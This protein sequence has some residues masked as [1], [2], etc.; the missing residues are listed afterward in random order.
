MASSFSINV[1][2]SALMRTGSAFTKD[3][4]PHLALAVHAITDRV[5]A[6]WKAFAAGA[7]MPNGKT[8]G[9]R[10]G[11]YLR[12][13]MQRSTGDFSADVYSESPHAQAIESGSPRRDLKTMLNSSLKV[14]LSAAGKRFLVIPFRHSPNRN[15]VMR[16]NAMPASVVE[17]WKDKKPSHVLRRGH[18][19]DPVIA[20]MLEGT[21]ISPPA[22]A[23]FNM[24]R[25]SGT[26]AVD[27][28]TG[29]TISVPRHRYSWGDRLSKG[30]LSALGASDQETRRMQGMVNFRRPG[31]TGGSAH[32]TFLTFRTMVEGSRG[33]I[34]PAQ[35]GKWPARQ[36]AEIYQ[37]V[38]EELFSKA[39]EADIR[40]AMP[41][42]VS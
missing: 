14:R 11:R 25:L 16:D 9:N 29:M 41:G 23:R 33:W 38:A 26:R 5:E 13:I 18:L 20:E 19:I 40:A 31:K 1:D 30:A 3:A 36:V 7:P 37:P 32:S 4:F 35:E 6:R 34:A 8:I 21:G 12:S 17:W 22:N 27:I 28:K 39:V 24:T 15:N 42:A 10:S 2:L